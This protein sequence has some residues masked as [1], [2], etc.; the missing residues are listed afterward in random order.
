MKVEKIALHI[1]ARVL[2][3]ENGYVTIDGSQVA[4]YDDC[5]DAPDTLV[6]TYCMKPGEIIERRG[7]GVY[8]VI[9]YS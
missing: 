6:G 9:R 8:A 2:S 7:E 1:D 5:G 4:V 3:S